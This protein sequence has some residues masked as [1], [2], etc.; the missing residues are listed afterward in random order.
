[1]SKS[2]TFITYENGKPAGRHE[3][4]S[5]EAA[6]EM[7]ARAMDPRFDVEDKLGPAERHVAEP[8]AA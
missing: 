5:Q 6:T 8:I 7:I 1:M 3:G 4:L 2:W